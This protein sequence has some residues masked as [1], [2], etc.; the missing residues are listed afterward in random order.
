MSDLDS[1]L[2]FA[3]LDQAPWAV[4]ILV[5]HRIVWVNSRLAEM[6]HATPDS[7]VGLRRDDTVMPSGLGALLEQDSD[8][9]TLS[10]G[11]DE[12]R[13]LRRWRRTLPSGRAEVH[14]FE[15]MTEYC[16]LEEERAQLQELVKSLETKDAE[17]GLLNRSAILQ[18]LESQISRSRRYGNPLSVIRL[19]LTPPADAKN[20]QITL[21]AISQEFN[22]QLRWADQIGRLDQDTLLLILPETSL[23]DAEELALTLGH[24]RVALVSR[25]E[26]WDLEL[27][28]TAWCK[29]DDARKLLAR[30]Q[31]RP[32]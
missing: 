22:A 24:D 31:N 13:R 16:W 10:L 28:A 9:L 30:L 17:T 29:G 14:F 2:A 25:A 11:D 20:P 12:A 15:D 23:K 19:R 7:L 32:S 18:A 5:D 21:R 8:R 6:L 3:A 27:S 1:A 4:M 26:G